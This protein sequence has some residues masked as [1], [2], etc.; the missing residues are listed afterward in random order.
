[1][2]PRLPRIS[3]SASPRLHPRFDFHR[4]RRL[5]GS[6]TATSSHMA[7][8][9]LNDDGAA[10][11]DLALA[12]ITSLIRGYVVYSALSF[13]SFVDASPTLLSISTSIPIVKQIALFV[14]RNTFFR[15]FVGGE[16]FHETIPLIRNLRERNLGC[17]LEYSVEVDE[18]A[19]NHGHDNAKSQEHA[20]AVQ[21]QKNIEEILSSIPLA[22]SVEG[23]YDCKN[24]I[25]RKTWIAIKLVGYFIYP[26]RYPT[27]TCYSSPLCFRQH[28][29]SAISPPP[30]SA[31]R[32]SQ[33]HHS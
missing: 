22:A 32:Q 33:M 11:K 20:V 16:T 2:T 27:L 24:S 18:T 7:S 5:I 6:L 4:R 21:Y 8:N 10:P 19:A 12:P 30:Y 31:I 13:P 3:L 25:T 28:K 15:H 14:V 17:M 23:G 29:A 26:R 1:M 9:R